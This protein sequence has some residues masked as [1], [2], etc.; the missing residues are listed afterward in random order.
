MWDHAP[1]SSGRSATGSA[2]GSR[3]APVRRIVAVGLGLG[4]VV[5]TAAV[6]HAS[7]NG[8]GFLSPGARQAA[9]MTSTPAPPTASRKVEQGGMPMT[10]TTAGT[11]TSMGMPMA[12]PMAANT[13]VFDAI[14]QSPMCRA[15]SRKD[16]RQAG[17]LDAAAG[18]TNAPMGDGDDDADDQPTMQRSAFGGRW[19][20]GNRLAVK[21]FAARQDPTFNQLLGINDAGFVVGYYGSG[22]DAMHPNQGYLLRSPYRQRDLAMRNVPGTVQTQEIGINRI[23]VQVG[24]SVAADGSTSGF[25]RYGGTVRAVRNPKGTAKPAVDQL[26]GINDLGWAAGFTNDAAGN[27][28]GYLYN[29]CTGAF[30]P[31]RIPVASDSLQATGVNDMGVVSGFYVTGKATHGFVLDHG[32]F[33]S[34]DLGNRMA[35]QPLGLDNAGDL[36]GSYVD[37]HGMTRGFVWWNGHLR[38]VDIPHATGTVVNGLNNRG[39]LVGFFTTADKRTVG[40]VAS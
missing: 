7:G 5:T 35:T 3:R 29:A 16:W 19:W 22:A 34:I 30:R 38:T 39:Q 15:V 25:V 14:S 24:F 21:P 36:V 12:A 40:F 18:W 28:H 11:T 17:S 9:A 33:H 10:T 4:A 8:D 1:R 13:R 2:R 26:L 6:A 37:R 20:N 31:V 27:S 32:T 23:G